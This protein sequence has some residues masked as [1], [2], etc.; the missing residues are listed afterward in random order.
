MIKGRTLDDE[1]EIMGGELLILDCGTGRCR[2][3]ISVQLPIRQF[4]L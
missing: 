1:G 3:W 2:Q 4:L